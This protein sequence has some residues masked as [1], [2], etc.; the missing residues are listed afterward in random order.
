[1]IVGGSAAD[2]DRFRNLAHSLGLADSVLFTGQVPPPEAQ[3]LVA[4][5]GAAISPRFA[6]TNTPMKIYQLMADGIPLVATRIE[7]HTQV[8]N[9]DIAI[10]AEASIGGLSEGILEVLEDPDGAREMAARAQAW[11]QQHYARDVYT[12]KMRA[13]LA[14]VS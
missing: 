10:L 14:L 7:S 6:G 11:H 9:D 5:A 3:R 2:V 1:L 4:M 8:L 13:M 12:A